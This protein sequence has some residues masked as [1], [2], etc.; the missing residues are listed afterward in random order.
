[1][2]VWCI[3]FACGPADAIGPPKTPLSLASFKPRLVL[4]LWYRLS[5]V[6]LGKEAVKRVYYSSGS[7]P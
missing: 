4:P 5:L 7:T 2:V 6:V 1:M 3:F